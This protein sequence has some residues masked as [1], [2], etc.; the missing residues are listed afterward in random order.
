MTKEEFK[1]IR[2]AIGWTQEELGK[3]IDKRLNT[4]SRYETGEL[5]I[6]QLVEIFMQ[7]VREKKIQRF[8]EKYL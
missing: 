1:R 5:D 2:T 8:V 3:I 4:I 7:V 6:P